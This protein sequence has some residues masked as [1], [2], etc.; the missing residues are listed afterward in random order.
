[1][2]SLLPENQARFTLG[3]LARATGGTLA[4]PGGAERE[5]V[6][7]STDSRASLG[8]KLFVALKGQRFDGH[9]HV[10]PNLWLMPNFMQVSLRLPKGPM[11]TEIWW[12][13]YYYQD[14]TPA[15]QYETVRRAL[16][17]NGPGG[18]FELEDGENWGEST[19]GTRGISTRDKPLNY[20][21][22]IGN[23]RVT[24]NEAEPAHVDA[25][26]NEHNQ[27]WHYGAWAE[28]MAADSWADLKANHS[29]PRTDVV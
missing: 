29:P 25:L 21:M 6:G 12:F 17:H 22:N 28:S 19:N 13:T 4:G 23:G 10:F 20:A 3:E 7:V 24:W 2:A 26:V 16:R 8:G 9:P 15:E 27:L 5:V 1:M 14:M 18:M 11:Q